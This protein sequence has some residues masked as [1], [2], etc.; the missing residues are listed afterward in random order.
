[1]IKELSYIAEL[2][3]EFILM[4]KRQIIEILGKVFI[5]GNATETHLNILTLLHDFKI[6]KEIY[7]NWSQKGEQIGNSTKNI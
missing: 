7:S 4:K 1:M 5:Y 3:K 2:K 6:E